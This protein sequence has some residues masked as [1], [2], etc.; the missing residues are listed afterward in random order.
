MKK[1]R[2]GPFTMPDWVAWFI[3]LGIL[4]QILYQILK[5]FG[6]INQ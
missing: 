4:G 5:H 2:K 1:L 6:W 3:G